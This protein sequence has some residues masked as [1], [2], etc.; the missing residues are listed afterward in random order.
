[1]SRPLQRILISVII[2]ALGL[3]G[4]A[5]GPLSA[6]AQWVE[7]ALN[8]MTIQQKVGQV[9]V[10]GIVG[11]EL[12]PE[13]CLHLQ[14]YMPGGVILQQENIHDPQQVRRLVQEIEE[15][16]AQTQ[17]VPLLVMLAHEGET[18]NRF[19]EGATVFPTALAVGATGDPQNAT[20][21]AEIT[22]GELAS[23]GF[24]MVL[25]PDAD[26][27]RNLDSA[28][29]GER[30]YGS[31]PEQVSKFVAAAVNGY[32]QAGLIPVLKHYPG[33]GG[34]AADS[35]ETLPVDPASKADL[36][37]YYLPPFVSG[38]QA[39]AEVIMTSHIAFPQIGGDE[40]PTTL[41]KP[42]L[43][44]LRQ[45]LD[46]DGVIM[47][48]AMRMK[49]VTGQQTNIRKTSLQ[50]LKAGVD[51]LLLNFAGHAGQVHTELVDAIM[52]ER[53]STARLDEAVRQV[54]SLKAAHGLTAPRADLAYPAAPDTGNEIQEPD[55][56][57]NQA[58]VDEIT[59][60]SIAVLRDPG[61]NLPLGGGRIL[62]VAPKNETAPQSEVGPEKRLAAA[63][64][65]RGDEV[66]LATYAAP[67]GGDTAT[68]AELDGIL[69]EAAGFERVVVFAWQAH[70]QKAAGDDWQ[71]RLVAGLQASGKPLVVVAMRSPADGLDFPPETTVVGM[72]GTLPAQQAAVV[73]V[74]VG[75]MEAEGRNPLGAINELGNE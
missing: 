19:G 26:V 51:L 58:A 35:H 21:I 29:I 41:S 53:L 11:L 63:L 18:V 73:E 59:R 55:W 69:R 23:M 13:M 70:L 12:T 16:A 46:F 62:V 4:C 65:M 48:D 38:K 5:G 50:A 36:E 44:D 31:D 9:I 60:R 67:W 24:N 32:N 17:P 71:S 34:V 61:G 45:R 64:Q 40:T 7:D 43:D 57:A 52:E 2:L 3:S 42:L 6:D 14:T 1:M 49:G 8:E 15:C 37:K 25:G 72:M 10:S 74:L 54:L 27:L 56:Q 30:S 33:H 47:S 68:Q 39:G 20:R 28:I 75:E 66:A 22:G